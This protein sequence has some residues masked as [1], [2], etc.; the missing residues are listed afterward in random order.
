MIKAIIDY[1]SNVFA[2]LYEFFV[3]FWNGVEPIIFAF[4]VAWFIALII[5]SCAIALSL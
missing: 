2:D 4:A 5:I 1:Y 3:A